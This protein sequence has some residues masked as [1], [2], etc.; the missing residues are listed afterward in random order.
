L[1]QLDVTFVEEL[2]EAGEKARSLSF[3]LMRT[4]TRPDWPVR[5]TRIL[6]RSS[7][8]PA[9]TWLKS[10]HLDPSSLVVTQVGC[11]T[12]AATSSKFLPTRL[13]ESKQ[14][15]PTYRAVCLHSRVLAPNHRACLMKAASNFHF[16]FSAAR[17]RAA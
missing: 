1:C 15:A 16:N 8:M 5:G 6:R 2:R 17:L 12:S 4:A 14:F 7:A 13:L 11:G 9:T 10:E 3:K